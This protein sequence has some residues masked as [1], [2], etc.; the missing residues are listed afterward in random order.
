VENLVKQRDLKAVFDYQNQLFKKPRLTYLFLELTNACNLNCVHCGSDCST[1]R[2]TFLSYQLIIDLLNEVAER[3]NPCEIMVCITGGEPILHSD[4]EKIIKFAKSKG[5][6]VGMTTN[7]TL[8]TEEKARSLSKSGLDTV[9][10]SLDGIGETHNTFRKVNNSFEKAIDGIRN[11]QKE[12]FYPQVVTVIHK[13]NIHELEQ[14]YE[15]LQ[16]EKVESWRIT[17]IEPIGRAKERR[18]LILNKEE[19]EIIFK[20]IRNKRYD[21]NCRMEVTYGCAHFVGLNYEREIRD[22]YFQ[23]GAGT[24]IASIRSNGDIVAC[25]DIEDNPDLIQGNLYKDKFVDVW[26][27]RFLIFRR[28]RSEVSA[29]CKN[30]V[31]KNYCMGDAYHTWDFNKNEPMY[32][33]SKILGDC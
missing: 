3:Y 16:S 26:E 22:F 27:N 12:G 10:V 13:N 6:L 2:K 24:K 19:L 17:T 5:F 31:N 30:C 14:M 15:F 32:C 25:L 8:V 29:V 23:C 21:K 18:D 28:D 1:F 11:F 7:A 33:I 4:L 9:A 20:Y